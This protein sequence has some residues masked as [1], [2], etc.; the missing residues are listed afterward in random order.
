MGGLNGQ[1]KLYVGIIVH[2]YNVIQWV[3]I[4]DR[5]HCMLAY[6]YTIN[7]IMGGLCY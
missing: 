4:I 1:V 7:V 2:M 3:I 5:F 6:M